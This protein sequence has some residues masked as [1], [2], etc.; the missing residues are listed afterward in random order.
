EDPAAPASAPPAAEPIPRPAPLA[1]IDMD[2]ARTS[3][4]SAFLH[5]SASSAMAGPRQH[6][7]AEVVRHTRAAAIRLF[8]VKDSAISVGMQSSKPKRIGT[9]RP[10]RSD[11]PPTK[12]PSTTPTAPVTP[13]VAAMAPGLAPRPAICKVPTTNTTPQTM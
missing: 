7:T 11:H 3:V 9:N 10:R 13:H 4:L 6:L 2:I 8:S 1:G 5:A 12:G